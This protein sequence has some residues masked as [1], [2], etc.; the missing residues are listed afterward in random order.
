MFK[1]GDWVVCVKPTPGLVKGKLYR[2]RAFRTVRMVR[3][4]GDGDRYWSDTRF[5]LAPKQRY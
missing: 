3:M 2:V 4:E 1:V 5:K